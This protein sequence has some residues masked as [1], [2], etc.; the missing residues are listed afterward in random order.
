MKD[1]HISLGNCL[2]LNFAE[3]PPYRQW[4]S[5]SFVKLVLSQSLLITSTVT[6]P[7]HMMLS[8]S[9]VALSRRVAFSPVARRAF[10]AGVMRRKS[11]EP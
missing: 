10:T 6:L 1:S 2:P 9:A 4:T 8:R 5:T 3:N 7:L 11:T